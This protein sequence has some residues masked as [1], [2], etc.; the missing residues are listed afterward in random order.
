[1][2]YIVNHADVGFRNNLVDIVSSIFADYENFTY[3]MYENR[4]DM[5]EN[6]LETKPGH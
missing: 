5:S 6:E 1:M 2:H 3:L 4:V